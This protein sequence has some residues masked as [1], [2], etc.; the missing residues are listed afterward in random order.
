MHGR[1][2]KAVARVGTAREAPFAWGE[3]QHGVTC[4]D[5]AAGQRC[6]PVRG[7]EVRTGQRQT[8]VGGQRR[9][10]SRARVWAR[11]PPCPDAAWAQSRASVARSGLD[12]WPVRSDCRK[13]AAAWELLVRPNKGGV[14]GLHLAPRRRSSAYPSLP[15]WL[16]WCSRRLHRWTPLGAS[17]LDIA[18]RMR[19]GHALLCFYLT[20]WFQRELGEALLSIAIILHDFSFHG[21]VN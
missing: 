4:G 10:R 21:E 18:D 5:Q 19:F 1:S 13:P 16:V 11:H 9:Q 15:I 20:V 8:R 6:S 17:C 2:S 14:L 3:R 7:W 12:G